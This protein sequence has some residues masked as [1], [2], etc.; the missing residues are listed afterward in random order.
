MA[1]IYKVA[2]STPGTSDNQ[3][4]Q[5]DWGKCVLCQVDTSESISCPSNSKRGTDGAGYKTTAENLL[6][7]DELDEGEGIET[8]FKKH[9]A[10]WHDSCR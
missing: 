3:N 5:I 2:K 10:K 6:A 4:T 7:F 8:S 9:E 1:K